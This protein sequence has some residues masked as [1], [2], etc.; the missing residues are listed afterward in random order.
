MEKEQQDYRHH[1]SHFTEQFQA[2]GDRLVAYEGLQSQNEEIRFKFTQLQLESEASQRENS[3]LQAKVESLRVQNELL[4]SMTSVLDRITEENRLL[5]SNLESAQQELRSKVEE[6][7]LLRRIEP[8]NSPVSYAEETEFL[9]TQL[10]QQIQQ[11][12]NDNEDLKR[13][14]AAKEK[15]LRDS[16][17]READLL[18]D[19]QDLLSAKTLELNEMVEKNKT[20]FQ[21][22]LKELE[23]RLEEESKQLSQANEL[24]QKQ[25][26][27]AERVLAEKRKTES[28]VDTLNQ[29]LS[30][31][32]VEI[33][34][35][36]VVNLGLQTRLDELENQMK[37]ESRQHSDDNASLKQ[38]IEAR[39]LELEEI[40]KARCNLIEQHEELFAELDRVVVENNQL[41][42]NLT[43][44]DQTLQPN[45]ERIGHLETERIALLDE[46][47]RLELALT[48]AQQ[49][50][51]AEVTKV[52]SSTQP[53]DDW[54]VNQSRL[55][56]SI[57]RLQERER[58]LDE[59]NEDLERQIFEINKAL[60]EA[61]DRQQAD[62]QESSYLQ[63][64][65]NGNFGRIA[66]LE[67][68]NS[69]KMQELEQLLSEKLDLQGL[70]TEAQSNC[71]DLRR[72]LD[73]SSNGQKNASELESV[74]ECL[75]LKCRSL[76]EEKLAANEQIQVLEKQVATLEGEAVSKREEM[77][78]LSSVLTSITAERDQIC[79]ERD[80]LLKE[81]ELL[82]ETLQAFQ[83]QREQLVQTVQQKHQE[84]VSY[85][86]ETLRLAKICE[87]LKVF[88][89]L[90][91]CCTNQFLI[92]FDTFRHG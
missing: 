40:Q 60:R 38:R 80:G 26:A 75:R 41:K 85:H 18:Q 79:L 48:T 4:A 52:E 64:Q 82:R 89:L 74:N 84:S 51:V 20:V 24:L 59:K 36:A 83:Q 62:E 7:E 28:D 29:L 27:E 30:S 87:E 57:S 44:S 66:E 91:E 56:E 14:V 22:R 13:L 54:L 8:V 19:H 53:E 65:L 37:E 11:L 31:K 15:D 21:D 45:S 35:M 70:L 42:A 77:D 63:Q 6:I 61:Q 86:S 39:E 12:S 92:F 17:K 43:S 50:K 88:V 10:K 90:L 3:E 58:Q 46:L 76:E 33:N 23:N 5:E 71:S 32:S 1:I 55:E 78:R 69:L 81:K 9:R 68:S 73:E 47:N 67:N 16:Q 72:Q 2:L 49:S 34:Q 25:V